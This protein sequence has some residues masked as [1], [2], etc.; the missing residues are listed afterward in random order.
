MK[1]KVVESQC[2]FLPV[3]DVFDAVKVVGGFEIIDTDDREH[4]WQATN[5]LEVCFSF[6]SP[7]KFEVVS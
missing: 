6:I 5:D 1:V 4:A 7:T 2:E 3:G